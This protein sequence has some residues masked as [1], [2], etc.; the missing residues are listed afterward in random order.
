MEDSK[1]AWTRS[2][3]CEP[4]CHLLAF[5]AAF[6]WLQTSLQDVMAA[7]LQFL[8]FPDELCGQDAVLGPF[9]ARGLSRGE[10]PTVSIMA[11]PQE[12][13]NGPDLSSGR[14]PSV[15]GHTSRGCPKAKV[16]RKSQMN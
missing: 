4:S 11:L 8:S 15:C 13:H 9:L 1:P 10:T 3:L 16:L 14:Q 6:A 2:S 5:T 7:D 12:Y